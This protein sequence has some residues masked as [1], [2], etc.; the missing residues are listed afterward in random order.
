MKK[1][2]K[3]AHPLVVENSR[4]SQHP[5]I[6]YIDSFIKGIV[7]SNSQTKSNPYFQFQIF[8][9]IS[10]INNLFTKDLIYSLLSKAKVRLF[11][12]KKLIIV[13]FLR[14]KIK[15][16]R[17]VWRFIRIKVVN[18]GICKESR[19]GIVLNSPLFRIFL[20]FFP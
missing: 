2:I 12:K 8:K 15:R 6:I 1:Y 16:Q 20:N 14:S 11:R 13:P 7:K 10:W 5:N 18:I 17:I 4:P 19:K 3:I 9:A